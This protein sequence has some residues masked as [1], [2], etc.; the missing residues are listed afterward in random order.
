[1]LS[2]YVPPERVIAMMRRARPDRFEEEDKKDRPFG[3]PK[4]IWHNWTIGVWP[5]NITPE[6]YVE[7][8]MGL[9]SEWWLV[10]KKGEFGL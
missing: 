6:H 10:T 1:M 9:V 8:Y 7:C 3:L 5:S 4:D 2:Y